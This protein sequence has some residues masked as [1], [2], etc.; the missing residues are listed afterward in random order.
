MEGSRYDNDEG[1]ARPKKRPRGY[2]FACLVSLLGMGLIVGI[3]AGFLFIET[4]FMKERKAKEEQEWK[5][6]WKQTAPAPPKP[7]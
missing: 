4:H 2:L 6:K 7:R 3:C 1:D 5:Q